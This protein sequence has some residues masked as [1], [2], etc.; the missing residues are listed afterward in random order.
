M[1]KTKAI[2]ALIAVGVLASCNAKNFYEDTYK[3]TK[4]MTLGVVQKEIQKGMSQDEVAVALGS[5]NIVTQDKE[6]KETW[7]YDKIS[8]QV[9]SSG[10]Q[11]I[12]LFFQTGAD[13]VNRKEASQQTLTVIIKFN[14]EKRVDSI[15]YHASKF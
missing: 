9:R 4:Q 10:S 1:S 15:S 8:S 6:N 13:Y 3:D 12:I 14:Q 5:P 11:G 7:I 2:I